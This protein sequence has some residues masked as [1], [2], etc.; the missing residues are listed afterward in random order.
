MAL[1]Q[2]DLKKSLNDITYTENLYCDVLRTPCNSQSE[3]VMRLAITLFTKNSKLINDNPY[4][5]L[6]EL[7]DA[8][9]DLYNIRT[10]RKIIAV[11]NK[12][13]EKNP[14]VLL[15]HISN[16]YKVG[17][18]T[19][20][21]SY[22]NHLIDGDRQNSALNHL[23]LAYYKKNMTEC[24]YIDKLVEY[25]AVNFVDDKVWLEL[26]S[27]YEKNLDF[28]K[29]I[30]CM[31]EVLMIRPNDLKIYI[32][33]AELNFTLGSVQ[34]FEIS[35]KYFCYVLTNQEDN[36]RALYG[37]QNTL[38]FTQKM[39]FDAFSK[40]D[41]KLLKLVNKKIMDLDKF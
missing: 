39:N 6:K 22:L 37:L 7:M 3:L 8:A 31:E 14:D 38:V 32:K 18:N 28:E 1:N 5:H 11:L 25:L 20:A 36:L 19:Q 26:T 23:N 15:K 13:F 10:S 27:Y 24:E 4:Q 33:L 29:A 41:E 16:L 9:T 17:A 21:D 2:F 40:K 35:K 30:F 12:Q 34:K